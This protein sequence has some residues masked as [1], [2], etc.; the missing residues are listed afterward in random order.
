VGASE[1]TPTSID[2]IA[3]KLSR[4]ELEELTRWITVRATTQ[5][6]AEYEKRVREISEQVDA[7]KPRVADQTRR[8]NALMGGPDLR[9]APTS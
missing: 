1:G 7:L 5:V 9:L 8:I 2:R 4:E 3:A 6:E